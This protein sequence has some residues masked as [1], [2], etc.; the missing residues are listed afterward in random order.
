M[1]NNNDCNKYYTYMINKLMFR[2]AYFILLPFNIDN[3]VL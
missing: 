3:I 2:W 1:Y